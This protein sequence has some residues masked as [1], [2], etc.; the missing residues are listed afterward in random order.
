MYND[1]VKLLYFQL[2]IQWLSH[3]APR[4]KRVLLRVDFNVPLKGGPVLGDFR[5][6]AHIP[7][8]KLL[9]K[10]GNTVVIVTHLGKPGGKRVA[11]L[12]TAPLATH[13]SKMIGRKVVLVADPFAQSWVHMIRSAPRK[14]IF[15]LENVRFWK[16]EEKNTISFARGLA[17]LGEMFVQDAFGV[18]HRS[19]ASVM[20]LAR[21]L[22]SWGGLLLESELRALRPLLQRP[23]RPFVV[24]MG[25]AKISTKLHLMKGF[26]SRAQRILLG[27][28][29]A[30]TVLAAKGFPIGRSVFEKEALP[31]VRRLAGKNKKLLYPHDV[32]VASSIGTKKISLKEIGRVGRNDY[33]FDI[34]KET[35][36]KYSQVIKGA[37][38]I[39][40]NGPMGLIEAPHFQ[41]GTLSIAKAI[42]RSGAYSVVGGGDLVPLLK[43]A[44]LFS[45]FDHVS[46]GGGS[47]LALV[48]GHR[49]PGLDALNTKIRSIKS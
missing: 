49:L 31:S 7:T 23:L 41:K 25:G 42:A 19:H 48:A 13:L 35:T 15:L 21:L 8:I 2:V 22:P 17:R 29:L 45:R 12:S 39:L 40:W 16:G 18:V 1:A 6:R 20:S 28:A 9:L 43:K 10:N 38:T 4:N 3:G 37:K 34:G 36:R 26:V 47:M 44:R 27:G 46:T 32:I 24:L 30:N 14:S 33:I 11:T 5:L